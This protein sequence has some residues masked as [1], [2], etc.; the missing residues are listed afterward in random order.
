MGDGGIPTT[1]ASRTAPGQ[2]LLPGLADRQRLI[3]SYLPLVHRIARRF[4]GRGE[5]V[6]DLVQVGSIG[7][8]NAVDRCDPARRELL[9]AY[10][11]RTVEGEIR[12]H[13]RDRCAPVRIPRR[14]Q[15]VDGATEPPVPL[16]DDEAAA[17]ASA[18]GAD[19]RALSWALLAIA[20]R[21]LDGRERRVL[22]LRYFLDLNQDE[23]GRAVGIS[24]VHVS[25]VLRGALVKMRADLDSDAA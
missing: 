1:L 22:L 25:R 12:R 18:E 15:A 21:S 2:D 19:E 7:L 10:V 6:E 8:I 23:V 11:A 5:R 16:D 3:E 13:L 4:A 9:T 24:Q 20:A 17:L 14:L